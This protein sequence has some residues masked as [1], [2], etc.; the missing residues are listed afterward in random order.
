[1]G[2]VID[3]LR[4]YVSDLTA[5]VESALVNAKLDVE[6]LRRFTL[7]ELYIA[8]Y[9]YRALSLFVPKASADD[10]VDF[11]SGLLEGGPRWTRNLRQPCGGAKG[12]LQA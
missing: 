1:M 2:S 10:E 12:N 9:D 6:T 5:Q 4:D 3:D 11:V 7:N 8:P